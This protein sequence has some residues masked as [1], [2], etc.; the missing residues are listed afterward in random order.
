MKVSAES[1]WP[2]RSL[3]TCRSRK[4]GFSF[5]RNAACS[6]LSS[7]TSFCVLPLQRQPALV[8]GAQALVVEDLLHRDR[9]DPPAF[10]GQ[11]RL[12]LVAAVGRVGQ[13]QLLDPRHHLRRGGHRVALGDRRQVLEPVQPLELEAPLPVVEAGPVDPAA[14]AGLADVAQP[15]RQLQTVSR[16]CASFSIRVLGRDLAC[17]LRHRCPSPPAA[18]TNPDRKTRRLRG[19]LNAPPES[20]RSPPA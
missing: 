12:D 7:I 20:L 2:G 17:R 8:A 6:G 16:R 9:R 4:Q 1:S 3:S 13:R 15:L 5:S 10:Q 11:Q 18:W 14:P 19:Q